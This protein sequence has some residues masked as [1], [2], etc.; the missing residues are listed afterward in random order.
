MLK[1]TYKNEYGEIHMGASA[2]SGLPLN[3]TALVG[4]KPPDQEAQSKVFSKAPGCVTTDIRDIQ[5]T[6]TI[7]GT[8]HG[9]SFDVQNMYSILYHPGTLVLDFVTGSKKIECRMIT[10]EGFTKVGKGDLYNFVLQFQA[11]Y[12][13]F[14][15]V[16]ETTVYV[17]ERVDMINNGE[18]ATYTFQLPAVFTER[19]TTAEVELRG[20]KN[21]YPI[22]YVANGVADAAVLSLDSGIYLKNEITGAEI[23]FQYT[24]EIGEV[25]R[26]DLP[27]R[28]ITNNKGDVLTNYISDSTVLSDFML[29]PGKNTIYALNRNAGQDITVYL[30]YHSEYVSAVF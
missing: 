20:E 2:L 19:R 5:R 3:V 29:K 14:S 12:P 26:I 9:T 28:R 6:L 17:F 30:T 24:P 11:D 23:D 10:S 8:F 25:V 27:N 22:I 7:S 1:I 13:Y 16:E 15:D 18:D 4:F 21:V